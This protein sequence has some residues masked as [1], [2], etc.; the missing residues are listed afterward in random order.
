MARYEVIKDF[1]DLEDGNYIY[2]KEDNFPRRGKA[3][4]ARIAALSSDKNK[5]GEAVI[6]EVKDTEE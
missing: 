6:K 2:R 5:R 3:T 1:T 4:K